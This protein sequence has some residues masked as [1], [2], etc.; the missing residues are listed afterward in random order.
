MISSMRSSLLPPREGEAKF[1]N[2]H[3]GQAVRVGHVLVGG[4]GWKMGTAVYRRSYGTMEE[5]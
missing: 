5:I 2:N 4:G 3:L 1:E